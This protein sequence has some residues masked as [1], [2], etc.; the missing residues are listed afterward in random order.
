MSHHHHHDHAHH[1]H[2]HELSGKNLG[3]AII[4]NVLITLL[5]IAGAFVSRS[6]SL[7]TDALHNLSDVMALVISWMAHKLVKRKP[8]EIQSFGY[9]RAEIV[10]AFINAA[11]L[12]AI[13][14]YL[15]A[16]SFTRLLN[17]SEITIN[18]N[19]VIALATFSIVANGIS[20]LLVQRDAKHSMNMKAAYLHLFSDMLTSIGVL[21]GGLLMKYFQIFWVDS[22]ISIFIAIYLIVSSWKL[23]IASLKVLMQFAPEHI[24]LNEVVQH[25]KGVEGVKGIHHVHIWQLGEQDCFFEAHIVIEN[26]SKLTEVEKILH[27]LEDEL[28][29]HFEI[30]HVTLQPEFV[31]CNDKSVI[32]Q[33]A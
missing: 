26:D 32:K 17:P 8:T 16:E 25:V 33:E 2:H 24:D 18:S 29:H 27:Q 7:L 22:I 10:A 3:I 11:T 21:V 31:C 9:K 28:K 12:L 23:V 20:V 15:I 6:L 30:T 14:V 19:W 13:S 5:Q 1:H 4:L